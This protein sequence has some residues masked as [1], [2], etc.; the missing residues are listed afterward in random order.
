[1]LRFELDRG[2]IWS[3]HTIRNSAEL[4]HH[5][6]IY[7]G[8]LHFVLPVTVH[9]KLFLRTSRGDILTL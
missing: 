2:L 4:F 9:L 6:L 1:M 3:A 8:D 5:L 7:M